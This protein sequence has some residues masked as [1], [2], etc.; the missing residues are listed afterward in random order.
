MH[1][2][3]FLA[4]E[5][6]PEVLKH[7]GTYSVM[8]IIGIFYFAFIG[9]LVWFRSGPRMLAWLTYY[10]PFLKRFETVDDGPT[11]CL[12]LLSTC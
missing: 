5:D 7:P 4:E 6:F 2:H 9:Y 12:S 3:F 11:V 10:L 8:G 1:T